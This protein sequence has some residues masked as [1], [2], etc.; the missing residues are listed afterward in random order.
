MKTTHTLRL[1]V[2]VLSLSLV[3]SQASAGGQ[4]CKASVI[5]NA[6]GLLVDYSSAQGEIHARGSASY[7]VNVSYWP[8]DDVNT[9][10]HLQGFGAGFGYRRYLSGQHALS[11]PYVQ[12]SGDVLFMRHRLG[13]PDFRDEAASVFAVGPAFGYKWVL[14]NGL[15]VELGTGI[16]Q[17][18]GKV[19]SYGFAG[20]NAQLTGG[21]GYS[22]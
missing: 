9:G 18:F 22:W 2:A 15:T 12:L 6:L 20:I 16:R 1:A 7:I 13:Y 10:G 5:A 4:N 21:L 17:G 8:D 11:G 14:K 3:A 19:G